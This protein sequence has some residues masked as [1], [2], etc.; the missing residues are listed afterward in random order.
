VGAPYVTI[1]WGAP[2]YEHIHICWGVPQPA[3]YEHMDK[4]R[5]VAVNEVS[6]L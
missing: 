1:W 5:S 6:Y 2:T 3:T 4:P